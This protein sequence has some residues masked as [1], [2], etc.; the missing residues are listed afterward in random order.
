VAE[1]VILVNGL[2]GSGKT[3]L[4]T[5]LAAE[6]DVPLI[7]KD[8]LK[9]ALAAAVPRVPAAALGR[10]AS[11][12]LWT[13]AAA[14]PGEVVLESW[15][16]RPRDRDFVWQGLGRTGTRQVVEVWC[17]VPGEVARERYARRTRPAFYEDDR[18]LAESWP[19][20]LAEA[21]PLG[22]SLEVRVRTDAYVDVPALARNLIKL[23]EL[24][25]AAAEA[26]DR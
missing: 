13:L 16:F 23:R 11:E 15:W 1:R 20:W 5:A 12:L 24:V 21:A 18:H 26:P 17:D 10:T 4:A 9:E 8:A 6:L 25:R 7:S 2:P 14:V 19:R 3:T 22:V